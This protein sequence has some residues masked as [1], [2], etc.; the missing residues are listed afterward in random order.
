MVVFGEFGAGKISTVNMLARETVFKV[1]A[2]NF[3]T[4]FGHQD[5]MIKF[6]G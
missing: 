4:T 1:A 2:H 5:R 3:E 6:G